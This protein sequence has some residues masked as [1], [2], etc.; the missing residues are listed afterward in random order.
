MLDLLFW[1][2]K[3]AIKKRIKAKSRVMMTTYLNLMF[4]KNLVVGK[5]AIFS[6]Y[7]ESFDESN[8]Q[9]NLSGVKN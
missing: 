4:A 1:I 9:G 8:L 2:P 6:L 7:D 3:S 5:E